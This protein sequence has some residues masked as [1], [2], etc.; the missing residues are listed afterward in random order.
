[1]SIFTPCEDGVTVNVTTTSQAIALSGSRR[2]RKALSITNLGGSNV[3][4]FARFGDGSVTVSAANGYL[5]APTTQA[6][7]DE[8]VIGVP[9]GV[10]HVAFISTGNKDLKVTEGDLISG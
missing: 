3:P 4:V 6:Q 1:M 10:T 5:V 2:A 7:G 8:K 9:H